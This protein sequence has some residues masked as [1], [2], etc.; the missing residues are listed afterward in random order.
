MKSF[1]IRSV[2][3]TVFL[4]AL[5]GG[6]VYSLSSSAPFRPGD[7]LFPIQQVGERQRAA[8]QTGAVKRAEWE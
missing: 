6:W 3:I 4:T 8:L 5:S 1:F 2:L 7:V